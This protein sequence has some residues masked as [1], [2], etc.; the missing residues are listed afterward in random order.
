MV[1]IE[2]GGIFPASREKLMKVLEMHFDDTLIGQIHPGVTQRTLSR[3]GWRA[4]FVREWPLGRRVW[5]ATWRCELSHPEKYRF[6]ILASEGPIEKGFY[7][8]NTYAEQPE[9]T[10]ISTRGEIDIRGVP[11][12][13]QTWFTERTLTRIDKQDLNYLRNV[14]P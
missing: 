6:E 9:G 11:R 12:F 13:L 1:K 3:E 4:T 5:M 14:Y 8:E 2:M 10:L 7:L